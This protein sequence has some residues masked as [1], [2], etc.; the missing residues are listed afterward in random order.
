MGGIVKA[1]THFLH[2][3]PLYAYQFLP[4][5]N[6]RLKGKCPMLCSMYSTVNTYDAI[7]KINNNGNNNNIL[8]G[9]CLLLKH[10][11]IPRIIIK[12]LNKYQSF[13]WDSKYVLL[14]YVFSFT[15]IGKRYSPNLTF[16]SNIQLHEYLATTTG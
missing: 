12:E 7:L 2:I 11:Q 6:I 5:L 10:G 9:L 14:D 3:S 16:L 4:L 8:P 1:R 15:T 13:P